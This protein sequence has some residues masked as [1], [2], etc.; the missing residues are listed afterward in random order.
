LN[1]INDMQ[2]LMQNSNFINYSDV[3]LKINESIK[4]CK[5]K[6][7]FFVNFINYLIYFDFKAN[8]Q[9]HKFVNEQLDEAQSLIH[10]IFD[11]K[12]KYKNLVLLSQNSTSSNPS[13]SGLS[14]SND[15]TQ[16]VLST[17]K[18]QSTINNNNNNNKK[19]NNNTTNLKKNFKNSKNNNLKGS[20]P[21]SSTIANHVKST[22][23]SFKQSSS[24]K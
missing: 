19:K 11:H 23:N 21:I 16:V 22:T 15:N 8:S 7:K 1:V 2:N 6:I 12:E 14:R 9:R 13:A 17:T 5:I 20:P 18:N 3:C 24:S 10:K 4:V